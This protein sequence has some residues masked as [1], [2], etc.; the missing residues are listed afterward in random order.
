MRM[1]TDQET[2]VEKLQALASTFL[3]SQGADGSAM[4]GSPPFLLTPGPFPP[5]MEAQ[6]QEQAQE[7]QS[8]SNAH[9]TFSSPTKQK[10]AAPSFN[11]QHFATASAQYKFTI[12]MERIDT[13]IDRYSNNAPEMSSHLKAL[14]DCLV[15]SS[16]PLDSQMIRTNDT[17]EDHDV[18][19]EKARRWKFR[20][21]DLII[22]MVLDERQMGKK[23]VM[24]ALVHAEAVM[25]DFRSKLDVEGKRGECDSGLEEWLLD[26]E[27]NF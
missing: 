25:K 27:G 8:T 12:G 20:F 4:E 15:T 21:L 6:P 5:I 3:H 24:N 10:N 7:L 11:Q 19:V 13:L 1:D 16:I 26:N 23:D 9:L 14:R 18:D 22:E 2:R 17:R